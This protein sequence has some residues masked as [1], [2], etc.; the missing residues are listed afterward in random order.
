MRPT[1]FL[2]LFLFW[3]CLLLQAQYGKGFRSPQKMAC[4]ETDKRHQELEM[5]LERVK[6]MQKTQP[7]KQLDKSAIRFRWPLEWI[8][9]DQDTARSFFGLSNY[10][11]HNLSFSSI[12]DF[13]CGTRT[14]NTSQYNHKGT[15]IYLWPAWWKTMDAEEVNVVAAAKGVL[16]YK[17]DGNFDRHCAFNNSQWNVVYLLHADSLVTWYGHLKKNTVTQKQ[18]GDTIAEGEYLGKVGSSG[19][20]TGPHLHFE[21][22]DSG[23]LV[24]PYAGT[25]NPGRPSLWKKQHPYFNQDLIR[26]FC[27][28]GEPLFPPCPVSENLKEDSL[29]EAT[30]SVYLTNYYRDLKNGDTTQL[31]LFDP[32]N[33]RIDS[34]FEVHNLGSDPFWDAGGWFWWFPPSYFTQS[35]RYQFV[36]RYR[37]EEMKASFWLGGNPVRS[38]KA[39][40]YSFSISVLKEGEVLVHGVT[41]KEKY[42]VFD[43]NHHEISSRWSF[44]NGKVHLQK[45]GLPGFFL[46]RIESKNGPVYLKSIW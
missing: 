9:Q 35:G 43:I 30:D 18:P 40:R 5:V 19:N 24:D 33:Q 28:T 1:V 36:S 46:I 7:Q 14:Y 6:S 27:A 4:E 21:V 44:E 16:V 37:G 8:F 42:Q 12:R 20:S 34:I 13:N 29:F 39:K 15:D 2:F 17:N 11:D 41:G 32:S 38:Q 23:S 10:M 45:Q 22:Y 3:H 31:L 25:C 26:S